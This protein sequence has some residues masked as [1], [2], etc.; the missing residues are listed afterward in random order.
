MSQAMLPGFEDSLPATM[1]EAQAQ[2]VACTRCRLSR[3]RT[4]VVWGA[5]HPQ[6]DVMLIGQ[7][8]SISDDR[9]GQPYSGPAGRALDEALAAV[10]LTRDDIWLTNT[11]KC[12]AKKDNT[13]IRPPTKAELR[14]CRPWLDIELALVQPK[15]VVV[16]GGPA[17]KALLGDDFKISEQHGEWVDGPEGI[18]TLATFQPSYYLRLREH[19]PQ[20]AEEARLAVVDDLRKAVARAKDA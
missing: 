3:G 7:G 6:A 20:A 15:V 18:P 13:S 17:A 4:R 12:V 19:N 14:A 16:I 8:P 5:G 11:H 2:A 1:D 9:T 10:G